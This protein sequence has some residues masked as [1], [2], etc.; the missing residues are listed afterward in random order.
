MSARSASLLLSVANFISELIRF[1]VSPPSLFFWCLHKLWAQRNLDT[2]QVIALLVQQLGPLLLYIEQ[3]ASLMNTEL[4]HIEAMCKNNVVD[5]NCAAILMNAYYVC[6]PSEQPRVKRVE[7]PPQQRYLRHLLTERLRTNLTN[8]ELS[9]IASHILRFNLKDDNTIMLVVTE[10]LRVPSESFTSIETLVLLVTILC[11]NVPK[12]RVFLLDTIFEQLCLLLDF[13]PSDA[14]QDALSL[15]DFIGW[16]YVY[17]V[18]Q[19]NHLFF[20]LYLLIEYGHYVTPEVRE[21]YSF[22]PQ[23]PMAVHPLVPFEK[24]SPFST[25]RAKMAIHLVNVVGS[26]TPKTRLRTYFVYLQHYFLSKQVTDLSTIY[27]YEGLM[28]EFADLVMDYHSY[29]E[30]D[31]VVANVEHNL[32]QK[33]YVLK[34]HTASLMFHGDDEEDTE[35]LEESEG[36]NKSAAERMKEEQKRKEDEFFEK[37]Y[38]E[39]MKSTGP[40]SANKRVN[41]DN[42]AIPM[43]LQGNGHKEC[44]LLVKTKG[45]VSVAGSVNM[46]ITEAQ[47]ERKIAVERSKQ[48]ERKELKSKT[49]YLVNTQD[50]T[51]SAAPL[52]SIHNDRVPVCPQANN[53]R[54]KP[55]SN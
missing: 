51:D 22:L 39:Q 6:R 1:R 43:N 2:I 42:M 50:D 25:I 35:E 49:I 3:V 12:I 13:M 14:Y 9:A 38:A 36:I 29:E 31:S 4:N 7:L 37:K 47:K 10:I 45:A 33:G 48:Q 18:I 28:K 40:V 11:H 17:K 34:P 55:K 46:E 15:T 16:L 54:F 32:L 8:E 24:D 41:L 26:Y 23:R 19:N 53:K 21:K 44:R 20:I 5:S 30:V 27:D 52:Q